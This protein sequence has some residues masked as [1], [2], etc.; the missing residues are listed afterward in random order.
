M[1]VLN[2]IGSP[3]QILVG[4]L[5]ITIIGIVFG[6]VYELTNNLTVPILGQAIYNVVLFLTAYTTMWPIGEMPALT[7]YRNQRLSPTSIDTTF[8]HSSVR[9][10]M[11]VLS[12]GDAMSE[13]VSQ[14]CTSLLS[15]PRR[16]VVRR[17]TRLLISG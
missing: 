14:H 12:T 11:Q 6:T 16:I 15:D 10:W 2:F 13:T 8:S 5:L 17:G 1:H 7:P 4:I 9:R 3:T